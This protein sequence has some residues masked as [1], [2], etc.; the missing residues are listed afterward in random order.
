LQHEHL[1]EDE[2]IRSLDNHGFVTECICGCR[3]PNVAVWI[4]GYDSYHIWRDE[5]GQ[6]LVAV[7]EERN[8]VCESCIQKALTQPLL[9]Q[10][11]C[12]V[13]MRSVRLIRKVQEA[14]RDALSREVGDLLARLSF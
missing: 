10:E 2:R 5:G 9:S 6:Y 11:D 1:L 4:I 8:V 12:V 13:W 7:T 3:F 14:R